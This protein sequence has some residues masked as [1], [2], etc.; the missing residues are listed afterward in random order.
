MHEL[1]HAIG[2]ASGNPA[3]D[4]FVN[5][6]SFNGPNAVAEFDEGG[7]VPLSDDLSHFGIGTTEAG[8][9]VLL[10][11]QIGSGVRELPTFLDWAVIDDFGY[12]VNQAVN[13]FGDAP[14]DLYPTLAAQNG[15]RHNTNSQLFLGCL[16]YTSPSPRDRTRSRMPSS[17]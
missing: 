6:Q 2:F 12:D 4:R 16:L 10:D 5:G 1:V 13:D 7:S 17:A 14:S 11:P 9:P 3:F 15:A 8:Q